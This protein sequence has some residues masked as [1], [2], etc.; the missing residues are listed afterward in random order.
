VAVITISKQHSC[1][2]IQVAKMVAQK[3]G[4]RFLDHKILQA[5][6][7]E[8][9]VPEE[10]V[11]S[12]EKSAGHISRM[13]EIIL[14]SSDIERMASNRSGPIDEDTYFHLIHDVMRKVAESDN[15]VI[16]GRAGQYILADRKDAYHFLMIAE[17]KYRI[18][19]MQ[20]VYG[21]S[22]E[23]AEDE[24]M[25]AEKKRTH[26]YRKLGKG[27]YDSPQPYHLVLNMGRMSLE[28]ARD[29]I[30]SFVET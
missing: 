13:T 25:W 4:Y 14:S 17:I 28:E 1:G 3:L 29:L 27:D 9:Q 26:V 6:A 8:A 21:K 19:F 2:G 12:L 22:L 30:C 20:D 23:A 18:Q 5:V 7:Q 16:L 24:I 11:A 10:Q 15:A